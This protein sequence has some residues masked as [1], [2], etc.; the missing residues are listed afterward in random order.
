VIVE[1][2]GESGVSLEDFLADRRCE[3]K[4]K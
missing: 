1:A 2:T 3:A 4:M